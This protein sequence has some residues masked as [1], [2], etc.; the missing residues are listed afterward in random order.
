MARLRNIQRT[1]RSM[2][3]R[4]SVVLRT[5]AAAGLVVTTVVVAAGFAAAE[6]GFAPV[7]AMPASA[8]AVS[9]PST[10][11]C[12]A[13]GAGGVD[14]PFA[15]VESSGTWGTPIEIT[16]PAGGLS[17]QFDAVNCPSVGNCLAVGSYIAMGGATLPL[18]A[19][20]TSGMWG[21]ATNEAPPTG[22][23]AGSSEHAEFTG[24]WCASAGNCVVVGSYQISEY[25]GLPMTA[26]ET[27]GNWG[28]ASPFPAATSG[29]G[30]F[31]LTTPS[32]ACK[33]T[34]NCTVVD[35]SDAWTETDGTWGAPTQITSEPFFT[36]RGIA[37]PSATT[38]IVV[39]AWTD[40]DPPGAASVVE[41]NGA[42]GPMNGRFFGD[43]SSLSA[44]ACEPT[45]CV[46]IGSAASDSDWDPRTYHYGMAATWSNGSWSSS[47]LTGTIFNGISCASATQ[48][49]R[50][51]PRSLVGP[52]SGRAGCRTIRAWRGGGAGAQRCDG[53][54]PVPV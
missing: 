35:G 52:H 24:A 11:S 5:F 7:Q 54:I 31:Y 36:A 42:W 43:I 27:S 17:G 49:F 46:A 32:L 14:D 19:S 6:P 48:C 12:T 44:I 33:T 23:L 25:T 37:C 2:S 8:S 40:A 45:V 28:P 47:A 53:V 16:L 34:T 26:V 20:E 3:L 39:G 1:L 18:L 9:C 51:R 41:T 4:R 10:T 13:V 50:S 38:C 30:F 21:A 22:A 29:N 15:V